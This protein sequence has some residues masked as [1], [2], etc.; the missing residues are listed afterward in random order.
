MSPR[1]HPVVTEIKYYSKERNL[2]EGEF[3]NPI[4]FIFQEYFLMKRIP[5]F[6]VEQISNF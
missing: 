5:R 6:V 4:A 2:C 3:Q 1:T